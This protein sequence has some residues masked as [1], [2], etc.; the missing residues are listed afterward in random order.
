MVVSIETD[1]SEYRVKTKDSHRLDDGGDRSCIVLGL[2]GPV[3]RRVHRSEPLA[4]SRKP[5]A[6]SE[7]LVC[8]LYGLTEEEVSLI[9]GGEKR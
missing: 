1:D 2:S 8:E 4:V 9:E 3:R 7:A 5:M 6:L